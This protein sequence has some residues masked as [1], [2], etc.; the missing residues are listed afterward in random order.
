MKNNIF[1]KTKASLI[2]II[3]ISLIA[4]TPELNAPYTYNTHPALTW[5]KVEFYGNYYSNYNNLNNVINLSLYSDSITETQSG[6]ILGIGQEIILEDLIISPTDT[7]IPSGNY[8]I[9]M[10]K[11][12][13]TF[14]PGRVVNANN[15]IQTLGS[16]IY[17]FEKISKK[18][19]TRLIIDGSLDIS[20]SD[21][22]TNIICNLITD[23]KLQIKG[24]FKGKLKFINKSILAYK[25]AQ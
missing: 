24:R 10:T 20:Y 14:A 11:E 1:I 18:S 2:I 9:S 4:C 15:E 17:F 6:T 13:Q 23:D 19:I 7:I 21:T 12:K 8:K 3:T 16:R 5:G 25:V 22:T